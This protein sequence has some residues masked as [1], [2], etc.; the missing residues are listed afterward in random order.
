MCLLVPYGL[1]AS[2]R[3]RRFHL[4]SHVQPKTKKQRKPINGT[5]RPQGAKAIAGKL[6]PAS[7]KGGAA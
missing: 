2:R 5:P 3:S 7:L 6:Y 4:P 1:R